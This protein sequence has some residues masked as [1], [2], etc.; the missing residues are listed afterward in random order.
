MKTHEFDVVVVG[1]GAAGLTAA[2]TAGRAGLRVLIVE[3]EACYGGTTATSGGVLWVPGNLHSA[4]LGPADTVT[5][6]RAYLAAEAGPY[7]DSERVD[8]FLSTT[9]EMIEFLE[10]ETEVKF[11]GMVYPDYHSSH[12]NASTIRSVGTVDYQASKLGP[13]VKDLKELL[14]QT[15]FLGLAVGSGVEMKQFMS[16]GRSLS[17]MLFVA[18]KLAGHALDLL[19]YGRSEQV[20][21]GRAL[22]AR[23]AKTAFDMGIPMWLSSPAKELIVNNGRVVGAQIA[24][25]SGTV[26]VMARYGVVLA[27]G[28]YPGDKARREATYPHLKTGLMNHAT[29]TPAGNNGDG[30]RLGESAGGE[31]VSAV[32]NPA[33]W[34]PV[35]VI[36]GR[37]GSAGV[38]PHIVDRQKPGFIAVTRKGTRFVNESGSYHDFVPPLVRA[39]EGEKE[40]CCFLIADQRTVDRFG[41]GF[42]KPFPVPKWSHLRSGYLTRAN[43]LAELAA[44]LGIDGPA[45][46]RTVDEFNRNARNGV[47]PLFG[48]GGHLYDHY[49]GDDE[50]KPNPN[51]APVEAGPFYAI[52]I[53]PGEIGTFAGLK[54]DKYGRAT[55]ASGSPIP[56]L[57]AVGNDAAS[58]F[59]GAYPGAGSTLGPGMTFGYIAGRFL[60]SEAG[61]VPQAKVA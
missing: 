3:K 28:G 52:K 4:S 2:V 39:C 41:M 45:L 47:D 8:T 24:T 5:S 27:C 6:A 13:Q 25:P 61:L 30:I 54:T 12:P 14:P 56:G 11:Y 51:L 48:R 33:A 59:S 57:Y 38:W 50:H 46:E 55:A 44:K 60:A 58:V 18:R 17:G 15:L 53:I 35:S 16:A 43:T 36:P 29:P 34:M 9:R 23:L 40:V 10:R 26:R 37:S 22:I 7:F 20:V 31:F 49:Q 21:R 32:V 1:T 19:R 42:V